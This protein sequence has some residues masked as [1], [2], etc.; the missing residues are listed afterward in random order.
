MQFKIKS[1]E[2]IWNTTGGV[3][4]EVL[5]FIGVRLTKE[6]GIHCNND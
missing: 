6:V 3:D 1:N 2:D 4:E 5:E